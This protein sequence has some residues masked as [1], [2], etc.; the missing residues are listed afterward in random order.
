MGLGWVDYYQ[1]RAGQVREILIPDA[2]ADGKTNTR[3]VSDS[4]LRGLFLNL[5]SNPN[6]FKKEIITL[7]LFG[8]AL[9]EKSWFLSFFFFQRPKHMNKSVTTHSAKL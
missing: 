3:F 8:A 5:S 9:L 4:R 1:L 6:F 2:D 7:V